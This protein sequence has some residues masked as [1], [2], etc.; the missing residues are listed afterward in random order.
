MLIIKDKTKVFHSFRHNLR[1]LCANCNFSTE[2]SNALG[3]WSSKCVGESYA[4]KFEFRNLYKA[5]KQ[6]NIPELNALLKVY[7]KKDK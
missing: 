7:G 6:I 4:N 1:T 3:G 5:M 2:L